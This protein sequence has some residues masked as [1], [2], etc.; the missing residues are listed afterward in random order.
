MQRPIHTVQQLWRRL[1]A[2]SEFGRYPHR[3]QPQSA[4]NVAITGIPGIGDR[5]PV[6]LVEEREEAEHEPARR[7]R[8]NDHPARIEIDSVPPL[9]ERRD[10]LAQAGQAETAGISERL[11]ATE[12]RGESGTGCLRR[13]VRRLSHLHMHDVSAPRLDRLGLGQNVHRDE[14]RS[15]AAA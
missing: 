7:A 8:G 15:L 10:P 14:G 1:V 11:A 4:E 13:P 12:R 5:D 3:L 9:I 6:T 2:R